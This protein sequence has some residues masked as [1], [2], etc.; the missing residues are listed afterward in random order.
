[1]RG[2]KVR[3]IVAV[4]LMVLLVGSPACS[5]VG[6][7]PE[8]KG[9]YTMTE[10]GSLVGTVNAQVVF[11]ADTNVLTITADAGVFGAARG[12]YRYTFITADEIV[13]DGTIAKYD[14]IIQ[15][16]IYA[17]RDRNK[18]SALEQQRVATDQKMRA[19]QNDAAKLKL[20]GI[21]TSPYIPLYGTVADNAT[22]LGMQNVLTGSMEIHRF[23]YISEQ[24]IIS[25]DGT[26]FYKQ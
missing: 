5:I 4:A 9:T 11:N 19:L 6:H 2:F 13:D 15:E 22:Y 17:L 10:V 14:R 16:R 21:F 26:P 12:D 3:G 1:M 20:L 8:P 25:L 7:N 23:R 24:D 18:K